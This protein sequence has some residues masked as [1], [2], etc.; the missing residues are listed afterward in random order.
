MAWKAELQPSISPL[1]NLQK[2]WFS[3]KAISKDEGWSCWLSSSA[4]G[5]IDS[6]HYEENGRSL[7]LGGEGSVAMEIVVP[8]KL[9][10][11]DDNSAPL[12]ETEAK[13]I[14]FNMTAAMQW[15]G[16]SVYFVYPVEE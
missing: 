10:W 7:T 15:F 11:D 8:A 1:P 3:S 5:R 14:L 9:Y 4:G 2:R 16:F 6:Y 13:R 12:D